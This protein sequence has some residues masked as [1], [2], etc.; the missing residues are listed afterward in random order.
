MIHLLALL[1][2]ALAADDKKNDIAPIG[3]E[4]EGTYKAVEYS[5]TGKRKN[6]TMDV[7]IV[8]MERKG[9]KFS[10]EYWGDNN[11]KGFIIE[12]TID[13]KGAIT[14]KFTKKI[15]GSWP[16]DM[17]DNA[18]VRGTVG[19]GQLTAKF[20][21]VGNERVVGDLVLRLKKAE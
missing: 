17:I 19:K 20:T 14:F 4:W 21:K 15:K 13:T 12:G 1:A 3:T 2:L 11:K 9:D 16:S 18:N 7:R 8:I 10:G 5:S 6:V